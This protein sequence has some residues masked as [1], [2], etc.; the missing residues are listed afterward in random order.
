MLDTEE[1]HYALTTHFEKTET[2]AEAM[3]FASFLMNW[4]SVVC[5][6]FAEESEAEEFEQEVD[7]ETDIG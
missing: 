5:L 2:E 1:L 4:A 3:R 6:S 7:D